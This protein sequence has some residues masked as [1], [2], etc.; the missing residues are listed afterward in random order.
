MYVCDC[1]FITVYVCHCIVGST[2]TK[3]A[4]ELTNQLQQ[5]SIQHSVAS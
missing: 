5:L 4:E 2:Q 3:P 1:L